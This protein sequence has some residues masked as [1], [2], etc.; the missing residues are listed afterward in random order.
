M[1]VLPGSDAATLNCSRC[2]GAIAISAI[3]AQGVCPFCGER[4][5]LAPHELVELERYRSKLRVQLARMDTERAHAAQWDRWYGGRE[6]Q[7]RNHPLVGVLVVVG[8]LV[9]FVVI[10]I[11]SQALG[12]S[13]QTLNAI[14]PIAWGVVMVSVLGAYFAWYFAGRS[15]AAKQGALIAAPV[16]C[17]TCGAPHSLAAGTV[18]DRCRHCGAALLPDAQAR[19]EVLDQAERALFSAEIARHRAERRGMAALSRMSAGNATP[20]IVLGSFLPMTLIGAVW[21]TATA[22]FGDA[23]EAPIGAVLGLWA[24]AAVNLGSIALVY[25]YR[26]QRRRRW[27]RII[28]FAITP[29]RGTRL[30]DI[31]AVVAWLDRHWAGSV[32]HNELFPGPGFCGAELLAEGYPVSVLVNPVG[33]TEDY[34]SFIAVRVGAWVPTSDQRHSSV[35]AMQ[36]WVARLGA[37]LGVERAGIVV[38]FD[39]AATDRVAKGSGAELLEAIGSAARLAAQLG[40]AASSTVIRAGSSP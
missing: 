35:I 4:I 19:A 15:P 25:V 6:A 7:K 5:A 3:A 17:P 21:A 8:L 23:E 20:Y 22:L 37:Q 14:M 9:P 26:D 28:A 11:V 36:N 12:L 39:Q 16:R 31:H 1:N 40:L 33:A 2:G 34:P 29:F 18:L 13:S 27:E 10:G 32:P 38:R 30:A 24:F